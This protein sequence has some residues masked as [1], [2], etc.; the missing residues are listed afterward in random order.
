MKKAIFLDRD[1]TINKEVD[2]LRNIKQLRILPGAA[3]AIKAFNNLG[4]LVVIVTNQPVI[5]RGWLTEKEVD[6]IHGV[7]IKRLMKNDAKIDAIYYCPHH[8]HATIKKYR[9]VCRC[10]K[11]NIG[12]IQKALTA[13]NI[14]PRKSFM[15]GDMSWDIIAGKK[16]GLR[17]ILVKTGYGGKDGKASALPDFIAKNLM[18][19]LE[20]IKKNEK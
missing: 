12:M 8:P 18:E 17:T 13:F 6:A 10:R 5:A 7:L 9:L 15:I 14:N 20:I 16:A 1:G 4:Y 2:I 11:P 3:R 19:A